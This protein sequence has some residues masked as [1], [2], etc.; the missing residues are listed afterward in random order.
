MS[1]L[2]AICLLSFV[3]LNNQAHAADDGGCPIKYIENGKISGTQN[4]ADFN[5]M[6]AVTRVFME[7]YL[8]GLGTP[9]IEVV[10]PSRDCAVLSGAQFKHD[11][12]LYRIPDTQCTFQLDTSDNLMFGR[13]NFG[14]LSGEYKTERRTVTDGLSLSLNY[15]GPVIVIRDFI[16]ASAG[17]SVGALFA[18][19]ELF[20][21]EGINTLKFAPG[22]LRSQVAVAPPITRI[23]MSRWRWRH[24]GLR[25]AGSHAWRLGWP[26]HAFVAVVEV[27]QDDV[28][29]NAVASAG[30]RGLFD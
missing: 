9:K 12:K 24:R 25:E 4:E 29:E 2:T 6:K 1:R 15:N 27:Q 5:T 21:I 23:G 13:I 11:L 30:A 19:G 18:I 14:N 20:G 10:I 16:D 17:F 3:A 22:P 28:L 8:G 7:R 26:E